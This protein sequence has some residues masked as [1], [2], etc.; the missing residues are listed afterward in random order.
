MAELPF[1]RQGKELGPPCPTTFKLGQYQRTRRFDSVPQPAYYR[2]LICKY[3]A[4]R[5]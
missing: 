2:N 4:C 5:P 3:R 1:R